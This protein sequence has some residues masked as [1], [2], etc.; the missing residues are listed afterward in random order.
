MPSVARHGYRPPGI[1]ILVAAWFHG[2]MSVREE[3][4]R[5]EN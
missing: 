4:A 1:G 3:G 2:W 5:E